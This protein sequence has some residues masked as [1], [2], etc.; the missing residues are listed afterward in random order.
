MT[1]PIAETTT[2]PPNPFAGTAQV[3][4]DPAAKPRWN[5]RDVGG[6]LHEYE[7]PWPLELPDGADTSGL[8]L[9]ATTGEYVAYDKIVSVTPLAAPPVHI[10]SENDPAL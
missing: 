7:G 10:S 4:P 1:E 3:E 8:W 6:L 9:T 5:L 2:G